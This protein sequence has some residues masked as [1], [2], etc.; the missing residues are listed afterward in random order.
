MLKVQVLSSLCLL[1]IASQS[2][3]S[4][5]EILLYEQWIHLVAAEDI[6]TLVLLFFV[7][8]VYFLMYMQI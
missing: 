2:R 1:P 5:E 8:F 6:G 4:S 3:I 7:F